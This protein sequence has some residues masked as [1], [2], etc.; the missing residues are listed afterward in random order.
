[1]NL[2][3]RISSLAA[4][5]FL[6]LLIASSGCGLQPHQGITLIVDFPP[7]A[8]LKHGSPVEY[9]G[10]RVGSV[11]NVR[12]TDEGEV[13]AELL[14][15]IDTAIT[16]AMIPVAYSK[17]ANIWVPPVVFSPGSAVDLASIYG[18]DASVINSFYQNG[19]YVSIGS[20]VEP[21]E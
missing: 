10:T 14:L 5:G 15:D 7:S 12:L 1:M 8:D 16:R 4:L 9:N 19:D 11:G 21:R 20:V 18:K 6:S 13:R 17:R 3:L 2:T